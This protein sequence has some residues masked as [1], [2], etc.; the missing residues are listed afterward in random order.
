MTFVQRRIGAPAGRE[1]ER[2]L[3][4]DRPVLLSEFIGVRL[5]RRRGVGRLRRTLAV[6]RW[7]ET[8]CRMFSSVEAVQIEAAAIVGQPWSAATLKEDGGIVALRRLVLEAESVQ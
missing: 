2:Q 7:C 3:S 1:I 4:A 8:T 6:G 5:R